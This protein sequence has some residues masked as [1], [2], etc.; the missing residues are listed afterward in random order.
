MDE[1]LKS[2]EKRFVAEDLGITAEDEE[3]T[4]F[5]ITAV[6]ATLYSMLMPFRYIG[7]TIT[8]IALAFKTAS[9]LGG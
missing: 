5:I 2:E 8:A 4:L 3:E 9:N 6:F 7:C 1:S